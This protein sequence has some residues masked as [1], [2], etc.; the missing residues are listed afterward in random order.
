MGNGLLGAVKENGSFVG[1]CLLAVVG[2]VLVAY[3][4]ERAARAQRRHGEDPGD[5]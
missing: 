2:L 1:V 3:L 4:F 5:T